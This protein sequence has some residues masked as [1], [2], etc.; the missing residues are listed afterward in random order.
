MLHNLSYTSTER[1]SI[2]LENFFRNPE[3]TRF[4]ISPDG[5]YLSFMAPWKN[6]LNLFTRKVESGEEWQVTHETERSI[7]G[8]FWGN[9]NRLVFLKD[10]GGDENYHLYSVSVLG[11]EEREL[12]PFEGIRVEIIDDLEENE[13]E[14][15][16]GMNKRNPEIFDAFRLN[17]HTGE[18]HLEA[19]NPGNVTGWMTDHNGEIRIALAT[20]GVNQSILYRET[21]TTPFRILIT[22][23][24]RETLEPLFFTFD[25][26]GLYALSN[27]GRDKAAIVLFDLDEGVEKKVL[28]R[29][30]EVDL[31]GLTYSRKRMVLT[32][33]SFVDWKHSE[34]F[35]DHAIEAIHKRIEKDI[36]DDEIMLTSQNKEETRFL[37]RTHSDRTLG[38]YYL[39][40]VP[41]DKLELLAEVSPWLRKDELSVMQPVS[42]TSGDRLTIHGYLTLPLESEENIDAGYH[43]NL[44]VIINPHGGPWV[45]DRWGFNPEVQFLANRG[46]AVLQ[47]NYRGSTGYGRKFW[48]ASFKEWGKKMQDD[49]TDGV[50]WII[51][52]GIADAKRIA[53][54]GGSYGGYA[55]L[56][57]LAFTPDLYACGIDY[58][59]VSN[60]FTFMNTIP[61]Y[62]K[63][64]LE[65]MYEMVGNPVTEQ[66]LLHSSSPVFHVEKIK[67]PLLVAQ[68]KNDPRVNINESNQIVEALRKK[69]VEVEYLVK[70]NEGHGFHNEENRFDFYRAMEQF[71]SEHLK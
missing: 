4:Q 70:E 54:Y 51:E 26:K 68:G 27:L 33:Y 6:R 1:Y 34:I 50:K 15:I 42:F 16:I 39:Y 62:W 3:K 45:R 38:A 71:L 18:Y 61:P 23:H 11:K 65:M 25:N 8:Y 37:V 69:G 47:I 31:S 32:S 64:Y 60:L 19:E 21:N 7:A 12:T 2:P 29:H 41:T 52:Q 43:K 28:F 66:E 5:A 67:A 57:G 9:N 35:L 30:D 36:P 46:Y 59:G 14:V 56:A 17:I 53:I 40:D 58:V 13:E 44:P 10:N 24:F 63:P 49:L 20:D 55:T 48:E 22:T